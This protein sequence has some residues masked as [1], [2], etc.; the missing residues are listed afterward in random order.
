LPHMLSVVD[1]EV[2]EKFF[3]SPAGC[4]GIVRRKIE[5][6]SGINERLEFHLR[7]GFN[8]DESLL[9]KQKEIITVR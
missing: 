7:N 6:N 3:L 9:F 5:R 2:A 1:T 8:N 4:A